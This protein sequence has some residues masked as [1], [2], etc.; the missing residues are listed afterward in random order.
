MALLRPLK[1]GSVRTYQEKVGLGFLDILASEV[2]ADLDTIYTAWN[3]GIGTANLV[4]GAV[5]TAKLADGAVTAVKITDGQITNAKLATNSVGVLNIID[6]Q[7]TN[8]KIVDNQI[9][10]AKMVDGQITTV[11]LAANAPI[12]G[13]VRATLTP[14]VTAGADA[15][16]L[17]ASL[18][19]YRGGWVLMAIA[20]CGI[21]A[22]SDTA[23]TRIEVKSNAA[24]ALGPVLPQALIP[25][26]GMVGAQM[27]WGVSSTWLVSVASGTTV[28][29][30]TWAR[31]NGTGVW[32]ADQAELSV[33]GFA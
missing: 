28:F 1:E 2:D 6:N 33:V 19:G 31:T 29:S 4:D 5:T 11:K 27:P 15:T 8:V 14:P 30:I 18:T 26:S 23:L 20:A 16:L 25:S 10:A 3:G 21:V 17:S 32:R 7:I 13:I 24:A 22:P 9:T 12:P